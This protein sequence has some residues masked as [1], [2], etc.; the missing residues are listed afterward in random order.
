MAGPDAKAPLPEGER[1][2][3]EGV[4]I[5]VI[6]PAVSDTRTPSS[7]PA[8]HLLPPGEKGDLRRFQYRAC[9]AIVQ[10]MRTIAHML[11][12]LALVACATQPEIRGAELDA[13][14]E[15]LIQYAADHTDL[16]PL[17]PPRIEFVED[18]DRELQREYQADLEASAN[19][20]AWQA[21][22]E[23]DKGRVLLADSWR[24]TTF[25]KSF[26]LHELVH[27]LQHV[28]GRRLCRRE[29]EIQAYNVQRMWLNDN[30]F[31]LPDD[32]GEEVIPVSCH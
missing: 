3:G 15:E 21:G 6:E 28:Q 17:P 13:L 23:L 18:V 24:P 1:G 25:E 29:L 9:P 7:A 14:A 5:S 19:K 16:E 30:G 26:L 27:Y 12:A 10:R 11:L 2:W 31:G 8:G 22:Y 32:W 20:D 4:R